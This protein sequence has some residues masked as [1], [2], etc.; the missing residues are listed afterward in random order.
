MTDRLNQAYEKVENTLKEMAVYENAVHV[1]NFD[2][3]TICPKA[4][5]ENQAETMAF[6]SNKAFILSKDPAFVEA[7]ELLFAERAGLDNDFQ[8]T[9]A[10]SL[11]DN[12]LKIKNITPEMDKEFSVIMNNAYIDWLDA[13]EKSDFDRFAPSLEKVRDVQLKQIE[14]REEKL[15]VAY[16]N[17]LN[18]YEKGI[19]Q[20]DLDRIFGQC[21]ERLVPLLKKIT[22]CKKKIRTDFLF[23]TVTDEQQKEFARYLLETIGYDFNR[24]AFTTTEHPF[25]DG[26]A[27]DDVRVTTHYHPNMLHS[28]MYSIIHE[29]GHALFELLQPAE[30][31]QY[32][33]NNLKTMGQHE[34]VSRFYE[35][36]I[37]RSKEFVHLIFPKA[38]EIFPQVFNDVTEEEF[39]RA[40]NV[41]EPSLIRT[42]ADEFTYTFHIIIRYELEKEIVAGSVD[43]KD[44]PSLW[45]KKYK[46]YLGIEPDCD[47][48][49]ILQDVHWSGGF[50]YFCT[51]A[52]GN[53]YN[54]M[55]Y[56]KMA[57][58]I[59]LPAA[60]SSGD[61]AK[62]NGW[63]QEK[64]FKKAD[65]L[66]P[67]DWIKEI[68]GRDFTATDFLDYLEEK[69]KGLYF[70]D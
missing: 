55:Y 34:S 61:F 33:I 50:G 11:H 41:V 59:D 48:N 28:S 24:G 25:T 47:R 62:I 26:L 8:K 56:N 57:E 4:A 9:L 6:L 64:V 31:H 12:Y 35:N 42:E 29:G 58:E 13:K 43:I 67:K 44:L 37:G 32:F 5:M 65:R 52:L 70:G 60:V 39:Y 18:D 63:M 23:R 51:Y 7:A 14:L 40:I 10:E 21:K 53:M 54:A 2:L 20:E 69:Y 3:E 68:T 22:E 66:A 15:P 27:K 30:N 17:L 46:E 49:G 16:D 36:R 1:L 19:S 45:N 38:K